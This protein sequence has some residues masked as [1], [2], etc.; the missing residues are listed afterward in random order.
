MRRIIYTII[1]IAIALI[2]IEYRAELVEVVTSLFDTSVTTETLSP[3]ESAQHRSWTENPIGVSSKLDQSRS[4]RYE[5]DQ[6]KI[7]PSEREEIYI[8]PGGATTR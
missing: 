4:E 5:V 6:E 3:Q 1:A 2:L 8:L 7:T